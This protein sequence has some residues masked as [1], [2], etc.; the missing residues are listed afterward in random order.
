MPIILSHYQTQPLLAGRRSGQRQIMSSPDLGLSSAP[1]I[2][3]DAGVQWPGGEQISW[4]DIEL[5]DRNPQVC[6]Q[7]TASGPQ[8]IQEFSSTFNRVYTLMPTKGV[9]TLLISGIP[10]HRIKNT[11]PWADSKAKIRAAVP[12]GRVLDTA[13]GLGYTAILASHRAEV[14]TTIELDPAVLEIARLNPWSQALFRSTNIEQRLGDA[15]D[16]AETLPDHSFDRIIHDPPMFKLAGHLYSTD[17]YRQ[18]HR[19]LN[20]RGR[21]FHY[22]GD[23]D[24]KSGRNTT[25]GVLQRLQDAGFRRVQRAPQAFGVIAWP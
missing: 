18:L 3:T 11:D 19:L 8:K 22:I 4:L 12:R 6:F 16:V 7:I 17:F 23:P 2:L 24:S 25:R 20:T 21:L 13:T 14:V 1:V 5:I 9:P 15:F 10:M